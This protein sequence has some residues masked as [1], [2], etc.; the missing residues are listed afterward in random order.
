MPALQRWGSADIRYL[1]RLC[2]QGMHARWCS[3]DA[4]TASFGAHACLLASK[5]LSHSS[6]TT[7]LSSSSEV[8][9]VGIAGYREVEEEDKT[10]LVGN[11]F[12]SVAPSYDLMND[13]MS[14]G[15]H[16]LWKDRYRAV[17]LGTC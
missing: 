1:V 15:L 16:R 9:I 7:L 13:L 4:R 14:A 17:C 3:T 2:L 12:S 10:R 11:V 5:S 6:S 8:Y